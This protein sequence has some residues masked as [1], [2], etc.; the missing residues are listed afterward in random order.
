MINIEHIFRFVVFVYK[1]CV[2][3]RF[4]AAVA[5]TEASQSQ[6]SFGLE[7]DQLGEWLIGD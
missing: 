3:S 2:F 4:S 6:I 5:F 7:L 1:L